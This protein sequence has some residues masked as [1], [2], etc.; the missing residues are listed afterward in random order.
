ME[1][2][3]VDQTGLHVGAGAHGVV[4]GGAVKI[5]LGGILGRDAIHRVLEGNHLDVVFV[6]QLDGE[7]G[8]GV[9]KKL[10][11]FDFSFARGGYA[12]TFLGHFYDKRTAEK[13]QTTK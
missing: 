1:F 6:D 8:R 2:A 4:K 7:I 13:S 5:R 3:H 11:H 12:M 10:Y 9:G